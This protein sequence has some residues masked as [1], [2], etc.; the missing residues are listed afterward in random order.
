MSRGIDM[1]RT[2][3]HSQRSRRADG[4]RRDTEFQLD[5]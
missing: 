4:L 1:T 5:P 2:A 3:C